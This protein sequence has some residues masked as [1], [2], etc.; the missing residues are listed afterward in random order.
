ME[1]FAIR[2]LISKD[3]GSVI[4]QLLVNVTKH[5]TE[6]L[7]QVAEFWF[8]VLGW[9]NILRCNSYYQIRRRTLRRTLMCPFCVSTW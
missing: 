7:A 3:F 1:P 8:T 6:S 4:Y 9:F 2:I 5:F